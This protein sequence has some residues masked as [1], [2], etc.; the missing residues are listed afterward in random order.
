MPQNINHINVIYSPFT[1]VAAHSHFK[2]LTRPLR[3]MALMC[4][5]SATSTH[6]NI[7]TTSHTPQSGGQGRQMLK[8]AVISGQRL[9]VICI[10]W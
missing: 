10:C 5:V 1:A 9:M 6:T 7:H 2:C 4:D 3:S 8:F